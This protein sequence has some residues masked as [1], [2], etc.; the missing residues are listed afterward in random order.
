M[1][2]QNNAAP[3]SFSHEKIE[4]SNFLLI[5]LTLFVLTIGGLVEIV[6][7]FFQKSTTEAV[8]GLKPYTPL[9]L[10]GRD[11]YLRDR[12]GLGMAEFFRHHNPAARAKLAGTM[13]QA[14]QRGAWQAD[15]ATIEEL[16]RAAGAL[17]L[18]PTSAPSRGHASRPSPVSRSIA[19]RASIQS[20][21]FSPGSASGQI[22][23]FEL[24][25]SIAF[26]PP[27]INSV[28]SYHE[29]VIFGFI[30]LLLLCGMMNRP[31]W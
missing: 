1:S 30:L 13:L 3:K 29:V 9:Q 16:Q 31:L 4:T 6:P 20:V 12:Y 28:Q 7:L 18:P 14:V 15:A 21:R 2:D 23:G 25:P 22:A 8:A 27:G 17:S 26:Q 5:A 19:T 10:M 11:V 24:V